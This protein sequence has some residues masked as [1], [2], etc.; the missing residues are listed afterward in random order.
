[1]EERNEQYQGTRRQVKCPTCGRPAVAKAGKC[2]CIDGHEWTDLSKTKSG[3][4]VPLATGG[5][6]EDWRIIAARA[7][8]HTVD[9]HPS[10]GIVSRVPCEHGHCEP[11]VVMANRDLVVDCHGYDFVTICG[12]CGVEHSLRFIC[13]QWD[14]VPNWDF[15]RLIDAVVE[16]VKH[17]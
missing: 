6:P 4:Q 7:V 16:L 2:R 10:Y 17:T 5:V 3:G 12:L 1:M 8:R 14:D 13:E 9:L 15:D 11:Q